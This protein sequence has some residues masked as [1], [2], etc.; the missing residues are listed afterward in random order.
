MRFFWIFFISLGPISALV[1]YFTVVRPLKLGR[2]WRYAIGIVLL[3]FALKFTWFGLFG[4]NTFLP[5]MPQL[6]IHVLSYVYDFVLILACLG[7]LWRC[8]H[9]LVLLRKRPAAVL[10]MPRRRVV[11]GSLAFV[12]AGVAGK[13]LHDGIRLPDIV[14]VTLDF[15]DLPSEFDGYR[16]AQISDLHVSAAARMDRTEGVVRL[17]NGC[18]PDLVA[19]TGDVVDGTVESRRLDVAPLAGL[20]ARDGV[21]GCTGNHEYYSGW[22][23]WRG[24]FRGLGMRILENERLL[25]RR[26]NGVLAIIGEN[27]LRSGCSDIAAACA[28]V[29]EGAFRI[30]LTHRPIR[31]AEHAAHGVRLQ[32][33]GHTHG[34]A[35][36]G[37]DRLVARSN[38]GHVRG[39]YREHGMTLY[40]NAGTGQWAGF[41]TRLGIF[42]EITLVTLRKA[43]CGR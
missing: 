23:S 19:V 26:G 42:P 25:L 4:G 22:D 38:E 28:L 41:P 32:L 9:F 35:V 11:A 27:D 18:N 21:V 30:L 15:P 6:A 33:S 16:I 13:G 36:L 31:L 34:G 5:E 12:A 43:D 10:D 20:R 2:L 7:V 1:V 8:A 40:V 3:A 24:V 37:I 29:P 17:V 14:N 39:I